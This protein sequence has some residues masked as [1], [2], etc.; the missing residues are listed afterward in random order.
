MFHDYLGIEQVMW[1]DRGCAGDDTHGHVDDITRFVRADTIVTAT[2]PNTADE[3]HLPLAENLERLQ[4]ARDLEGEPF[5]DCRA[6][7]AVAG[8]VPGAA[9]AGELCEFLYREWAG[10]GAD[11]Q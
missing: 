11:V 7:D 9:A 5:D 2:E 8:C 6:A 10:A 1:M 4:A 3:N